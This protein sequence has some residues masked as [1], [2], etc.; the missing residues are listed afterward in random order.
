[1]ARGKEAVQACLQHA[2]DQSFTVTDKRG[3]NFWHLLF[4]LPNRNKIEL[5]ANIQPVGS[6]S[7]AKYN[8]D[9]LNRTALHYACMKRNVWLAN[10]S[11][12]AEE[13][14]QKFSDEHINK[15][16]IFGRT[17][18]HYHHHHHHLYCTL[19][20]ELKNNKTHIKNTINKKEKHTQHKNSLA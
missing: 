13:F 15:Q 9:D 19:K 4:L 3:R 2:D 7:D 1:V 8:S 11:W 20:A 14:I 18:L 10:W 6:A 16:D 17:A 12:L 5:A